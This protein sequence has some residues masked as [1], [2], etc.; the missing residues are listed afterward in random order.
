VVVRLTRL[1]AASSAAARRVPAHAGRV[2]APASAA[3]AALLATALLG[4]ACGGPTASGEPPAIVEPPLPG[5]PATPA[6][7]LAGTAVLVGAGDIAACEKKDRAAATA[8]LVTTVAP[9]T[10]VVF[11][12]GDNAYPSGSAD[13]FRRCYEPTWGAFRDRTR[14]AAGNHEWRTAGAAGYRGYFGSAAGDDATWYAYD[15]G[16]WRVVVLDSACG[17]VGGCDAGSPQGRWLAAE[18]AAHRDG[19]TLALWHVPRFSSG[20]EHGSQEDVAPLWEAAVAGGVDLVLNGHE[21]SYER[22]GRLGPDGRSAADGVR[23]IVVGS[24]GGEPYRFGAPLPGSEA[25]VTGY[26]AVL[27]LELAADGYRWQLVGDDGGT[28]VLDAGRDTCRP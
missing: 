8:R 18:L 20:A 4:A 21:H 17:K 5:P 19:C 13:D 27:M 6:P 2:H 14:P 11:T 15:A 24:G 23:Q 9:P 1:I 3:A 26:P 28:V 10:A 25:R 12:T 22:F 7:M 16:A